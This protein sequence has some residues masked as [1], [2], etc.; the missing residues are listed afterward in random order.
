MKRASLRHLEVMITPNKINSRNIT[1]YTKFYHIISM[2]SFFIRAPLPFANRTTFCVVL[3]CLLFHLLIVFVFFV[4]CLR[5][6]ERNVTL[7]KICHML[8][9]PSNVII[10]E[11][12]STLTFASLLTCSFVSMLVVTLNKCLG[13]TGLNSVKEFIYTGFLL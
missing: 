3:F 7:L 9:N 11:T 5:N 12:K 1:N 13:G 10:W 2:S 8:G 4:F 6:N